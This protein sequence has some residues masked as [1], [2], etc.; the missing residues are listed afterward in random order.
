MN[1]FFK[2]ASAL[3][4][5]TLAVA[6]AMA[7]PTGLPV[8]PEVPDGATFVL[9]GPHWGQKATVQ[10]RQVLVPPSGAYGNF[11]LPDGSWYGVSVTPPSGWRST[12]VGGAAM[13]PALPVSTL[14]PLPLSRAERLS[15]RPIDPLHSGGSFFYSQNIS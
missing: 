3:L 5:S 14:T 10:G 1:P 11:Q 13:A 6:P 2:F 7:Q 15:N 8:P 12:I 4:A 9:F